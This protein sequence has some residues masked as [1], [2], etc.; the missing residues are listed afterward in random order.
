MPNETRIQLDHIL[1]E[2]GLFLETAPDLPTLSTQDEFMRIG[3]RAMNYLLVLSKAGVSL[4]RPHVSGYLRRHAPLIG[5]AVRLVKLYEG[6]LGHLASREKD[7]A[8]VFSRPFIE[9]AIKLHY[10][11]RSDRHSARS[12]VETSYRAEKE[13]LKELNGVR[14]ER[15]LTPFE[16]MMRS[17][18]AA[19]IRGAGITQRALL[20]R[21]N[22]DID[23]KNVRTLLEDLDWE[24]A[25]AFGFAGASHFVHGTW[26]DL[27]VHHLGREGR[28]YY[29]DTDFESPDTRMIG[30]H[31]ILLIY[32]MVAVIQHFKLDREN[33]II[34]PLLSMRDFFE[35]FMEAQREQIPQ[36]PPVG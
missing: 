35:G 1:R 12:F 19:K 9:T 15:P 4:P 16:A 33:R 34:V 14:E 3:V 18:I 31:S 5:L 29:P 17:D 22:W 24:V 23:G 26:H 30:P 2:T 6:Y 8:Q 7:L 27:T 20:T 28:K 11:L 21:T 13:M 36:Q 32:A 25:Y 10:L